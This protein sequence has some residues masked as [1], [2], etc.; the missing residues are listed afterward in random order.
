MVRGRKDGVIECVGAREMLT[1]SLTMAHV[2]NKLNFSFAIITLI[3]LNNSLLIFLYISQFG[4]VL[5]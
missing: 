3:L 1:T 5:N 2:H 4:N